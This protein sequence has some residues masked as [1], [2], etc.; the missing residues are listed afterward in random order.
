MLQRALIGSD[1]D[2][3]DA[4]IIEVS[5]TDVLLQLHAIASSFTTV[6][7]IATMSFT[8]Y[9]KWLLVAAHTLGVSFGILGVH[10]YAH[11]L[12]H[13]YDPPGWWERLPVV[14]YTYYT[15]E[16]EEE[17]TVNYKDNSTEHQQDRVQV[18]RVPKAIA[19]TERKRKKQ[20]V[21]SFYTG[22][23]VTPVPKVVCD[24][25]HRYHDG[26]HADTSTNFCIVMLGFDWVAGTVYGGGLESQTVER[27]HWNRE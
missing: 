9:T 24:M 12:N 18:H 13:D 1:A 6:F 11:S 20:Q 25:L 26:H 23:P 14:P 10:N 4:A 15:D 7:A 3:V 8:Y 22:Y 2:G 19:S 16:D 27:S 17:V 5:S 21:L